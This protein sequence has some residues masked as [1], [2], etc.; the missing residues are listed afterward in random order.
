MFTINI[1]YVL[2]VTTVP[3]EYGYCPQEEA[4]KWLNFLFDVLDAFSDFDEP[5]SAMQDVACRG[6]AK[7]LES[8]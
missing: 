3:E 1:I 8:K 4:V 7:V 2:T 6:I 5:I